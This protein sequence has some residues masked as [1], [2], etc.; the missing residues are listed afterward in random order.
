MP[1]SH[2]LVV[3]RQ[4]LCSLWDYDNMEDSFIYN[5][6]SACSSLTEMANGQ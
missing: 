4:T 3:D 5:S 2:L 6:K 1:K